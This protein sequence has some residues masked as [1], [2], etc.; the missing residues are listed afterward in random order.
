MDA[1]SGIIMG[2]PWWVYAILVYLCVLGFQATKPRKVSVKRLLMLPVLLTIWSILGLYDRLNGR[3]GLIIAWVASV[4]IGMGIGWL[5]ARTWKVTF[6]RKE[7]TVHLPGTW[8]T[9]VLILVIFC[10]KYYFGYKYAT[11]IAAFDNTTFFL[12][13]LAISGLITGLFFGRVFCYIGRSP[14]K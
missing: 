13:D 11:D 2:T 7:G 5:W 10:A 9:L 6:D 14:T 3:Y 12:V 8:S 4:M 1:V